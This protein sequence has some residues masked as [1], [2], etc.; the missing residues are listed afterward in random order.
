[1]DQSS[2]ASDAVVN[3]WFRLVD[4]RHG[5]SPGNHYRKETV[6]SSGTGGGDA[7]FMGQWERECIEREKSSV[8]ALH[9]E[10]VKLCQKY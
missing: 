5:S 4:H 3:T 1:M 2:P 7:L 10:K 8:M 9:P 6:S